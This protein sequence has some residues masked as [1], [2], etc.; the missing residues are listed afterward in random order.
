MGRC[1]GC[2]GRCARRLRTEAEELRIWSWWG[3]RHHDSE[4]SELR[5]QLRL[6]EPDRPHFLIYTVAEW[7]PVYTHKEAVQILFEAWTH[8]SVHE[9]L[10]LN[11]YIVLENQLHAMAQALTFPRPGAGSSPALRAGLVGVFTDW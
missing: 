8:H 9:G 3:G 11:G 6:A 7:L 2:S 10:R 5:R 4:T 1:W